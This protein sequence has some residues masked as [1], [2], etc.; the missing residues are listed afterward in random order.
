MEA[1]PKRVWTR[2]PVFE[3]FPVESPVAAV[4]SA[5][6]S[7]AALVAVVGGF[8]PAHWLPVLVSAP[9]RLWDETMMR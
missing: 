1:R 3:P 2:R 9:H 7:A 6:L 5:S 4:G 8:L